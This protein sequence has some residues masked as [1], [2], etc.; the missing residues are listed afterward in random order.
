MSFLRKYRTL[1]IILTILPFLSSCGLIDLQPPWKRRPKKQRRIK[2]KRARQ[3]DERVKQ[4][5]RD[6]KQEAPV[7]QVAQPI[8][9]PKQMP[10]PVWDYSGAAG[11]SAWA[12]LKPEY[13]GCQGRMQSPI[14]LRWSRPTTTRPLLFQYRPSPFS[15]QD[16]GRTIRIEPAP[17]NMAILGAESFALKGIEFHTPSEHTL[18]GRRFPLEVQFFHQN[19]RGQWAVVSVFAREGAANQALEAAWS[20]VPYQKGVNKT[21]SDAA[22]PLQTLL[23]GPKTHYHYMGSLTTPPCTEGVNWSVLNN[24]ITVSKEQIWAFKAL[25]SQNNRPQQ[26]VNGRSVRNF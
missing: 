4:V 9:Q 26:P 7:E 14:D 24:P 23:P 11:P 17:G 19:S 22:L 15:I 21:V 8:E 5:S 10:L 2:K 1:L 18:S 25:Y 16:T 12:S 3:A 6:K 13:F 20:Q